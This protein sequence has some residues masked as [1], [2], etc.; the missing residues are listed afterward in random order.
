M[1]GVKDHVGEMPFEAA[2]SLAEGFA[3]GLFASDVG[4]GTRVVLELG[5]G[6]GVEGAVELAVAAAVEAMSLSVA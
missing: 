1:E 5:E 2:D 3:L 6:D 4:L